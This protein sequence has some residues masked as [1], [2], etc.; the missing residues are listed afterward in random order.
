MKSS[1]P[2]SPDVAAIVSDLVLAALT[3]KV[4]SGEAWDYGWSHVD[5][6]RSPAAAMTHGD[7]VGVQLNASGIEAFERATNRLLSSRVVRDCYDVE[8]FWGAMASVVGKLPLSADA[9]ELSSKIERQIRQII[10]PPKS[11][12]VSP[13]AN[14]APPL[15]TL[16]FGSLIVGHFDERFRKLLS[17]R[18][19]RAVFTRPNMDLW[20]AG[21]HEAGRLKGEPVTLLAYMGE[22]QLDRAI[23]DAG[24]ALENLISI[25]LMLQADLD[26]LSLHSLRGDLN[27]PGLRGLA[28]DRV[29]LMRISESVREASREIGCQVFVDG[30]FG[31]RTTVHWYSADAF[32]LEKL[33]TE[34]EKRTTAERLLVGSSA[35]D[36]RLLIAARW[37][38][39]AHWSFD[40]VDSVL[41]LGISF[42]S[43]LSEQGPTPGRVLSERFALLDPDANNRRQRYHQFQTQYYPARSA[44]AHGAQRKS[45][46]AEF[47]RGMAAQ[48]RW[49]FQ[50][51]LDLTRRLAIKSEDEYKKMWEKFKWEGPGALG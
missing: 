16:D 38:A 44:V 45:L 18:V 31:P 46:G 50:R 22:S 30:V 3:R 5:Y 43:M 2:K 26:S 7:G 4:A 17:S 33:L 42:D 6:R 37:H 51:I 48:A 10:D 35:I 40:P 15:A 21:S 12:V 9:K 11:L 14:I 32:P 27:R 1:M 47:V 36:R 49:T 28:V 19:G 25:A 20:W 41:A 39:K 23:S 13:V 29:S 24:E 8:E 34:T